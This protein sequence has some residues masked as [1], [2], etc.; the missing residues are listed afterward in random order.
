MPIL[1]NGG[2]VR[3]INK[4]SDNDEGKEIEQLHDTIDT[5]FIKKGVNKFTSSI[6][7]SNNESISKMNEDV[8]MNNTFKNEMVNEKPILKTSELVVTTDNNYNTVYKNLEETI[9]L[10]K[11]VGERNA[12]FLFKWIYNVY[13]CIFLPSIDNQYKEVLNLTKT[14]L[15]IF[16]VLIDDLADNEKTRNK[17]LLDTCM[18][19][20]WSDKKDY[21]NG[22]LSVAST[23]WNDCIKKIETFPRYEMFKEIFYFDLQQFMNCNRYSY[24]VNSNNTSNFT[25]DKIYLH[26]GVMVLLH[27]DLDLMCSPNFD[28][29]ELGKLRII[30]YQVQ[31]Y[32]HIGNMLSTY[33]REV[34][35]LDVSSPIIS[36]ALR[37][38]I[39]EKDILKKDPEYAKECLSPLIP[40]FKK[41]MKE[42]LSSINKYID[43]IETIDMN[44]FYSRLKEVGDRFLNRKQYWRN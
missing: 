10:Y 26:H 5:L 14:K 25:E 40:I 13:D 4:F 17:E 27:C 39:I 3:F 15:G 33:S 11:S 19:I 6:A 9:N 21:K 31:D 23:I 2:I 20:P 24:L 29:N 12:D 32:I 30:N 8:V 36:L 42:N 41:R 16:N 35:E 37:K 7:F 43:E 34:E 1:T 44:E 38:G 22:Y 28:Y 18:K